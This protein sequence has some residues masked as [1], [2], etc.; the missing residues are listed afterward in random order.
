MGSSFPYDLLD[1]ILS[2]SDEE[3]TLKVTSL[4]NRTFSE[5]SQKYLFRAIYLGPLTDPAFTMA[6][7][8]ASVI[9][10][11][12]Q[13]GSYVR[14]LEIDYSE[15]PQSISWISDDESMANIFPALDNLHQLS[16]Y[17][18][19]VSNWE[20]FSPSLQ[21]ALISALESPRLR[22]IEIRGIADFPLGIVKAPS[23]QNF[24]CISTLWPRDGELGSYKEPTPSEGSPDP[25]P[26]LKSLV[27]KY[28]YTIDCKHIFSAFNLNHL[29]QFSFSTRHF[30]EHDDLTAIFEASANTLQTVTIYLENM[31]GM[32]F[33][34]QGLIASFFLVSDTVPFLPPGVAGVVFPH[35][36][37]MPIVDL[38]P[39]QK[40]K[41]LMI[42]TNVVATF[43]MDGQSGYTSRIPWLVECLRLLPD[44]PS[45]SLSEIFLDIN[46]TL[47]EDELPEGSFSEFSWESLVNILLSSKLA[48]VRRFHLK[49]SDDDKL[50][51]AHLMD[52]L[53]KDPYLSKLRDK[54]ILSLTN[55]VSSI[56]KNFNVLL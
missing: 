53:E 16:L 5:I 30:G 28:L 43:S 17:G 50:L 15:Y 36:F 41:T 55:G 14:H 48:G 18:K 34:S 52:F 7:K 20:Q 26:V 49:V 9:Q 45:N 27:V 39:L 32:F 33:P 21:N 42:E 6:E 23:V 54:G 8:F 56:E 51:P 3:D 13:I 4:V 25:R 44:P 46:F 35:S 11:S 24:S 37:L 31:G 29:V 2:L 40:L 47:M 12:P 38:S 10:S 22:S 1:A 19:P